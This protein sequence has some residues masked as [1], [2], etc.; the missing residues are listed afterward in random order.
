MPNESECR[1]TKRAR[2]AEAGGGETS[3]P[4]SE[5]TKWQ[6]Q[7]TENSH[8]RQK[9]VQRL[10]EQGKDEEDRFEEDHNQEAI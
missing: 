5:F 1:G 4:L 3:G 9:L 8:M 6:Q 2:G 7:K 10:Q